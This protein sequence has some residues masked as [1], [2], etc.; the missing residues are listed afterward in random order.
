MINSVKEVC[1]L[2]YR[3]YT[4]CVLLRLRPESSGLWA[5][6]L[7]TLYELETN[8][9][10]IGAQMPTCPL[11]WRYYRFPEHTDP[12][13]SFVVKSFAS[14][15][16][17]LKPPKPGRVVRRA[18]SGTTLS[19]PAMATPRLPDCLHEPAGNRLLP[20]IRQ[21]QLTLRRRIRAHEP[22]H[23]RTSLEEFYSATPHG[24]PIYRLI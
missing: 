6:S 20:S 3:R 16:D 21:S 15:A 12:C 1:N 18:P 4:V 7:S 17:V 24:Q 23:S 2:L 19:T 13:S 22:T 10:Y 14:F 8:W 9:T 5:A 11:K